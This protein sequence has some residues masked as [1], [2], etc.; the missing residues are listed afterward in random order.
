MDFDSVNNFITF[1]PGRSSPCL[2]PRTWCEE[3]CGFS[4]KKQG[5]EIILTKAL[6]KIRAADTFGFPSPFLLIYSEELFLAKES[7]CA[8]AL[9]NEIC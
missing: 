9:N 6:K 3:L 7:C 1:G 4:T 8:A 5:G 2:R